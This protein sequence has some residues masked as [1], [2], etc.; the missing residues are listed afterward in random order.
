MTPWPNIHNTYG[1]SHGEEVFSGACVCLHP[2]GASMIGVT[3][4]SPLWKILYCTR[5]GLSLGKTFSWDDVGLHSWNIY[6]TY[7]F[8]SWRR[9]S[10]SWCVGNDMKSHVTMLFWTWRD[11]LR[12]P[13]EN[14]YDVI[15]TL[16][17]YSSLFTV[18]EMYSSVLKCLKCSR[19]IAFVKG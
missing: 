18:L 2:P 19:D 6:I 13:D 9:L 10:Q 12:L 17:N 11:Q 7:G 1:V 4:C 15:L 16:Q 14:L 5:M 8:L 3:V